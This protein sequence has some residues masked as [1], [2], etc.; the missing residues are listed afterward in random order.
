MLEAFLSLKAFYYSN[1]GQQE[2]SLN[3]PAFINKIASEIEPIEKQIKAL[4]A[5]N[6]QSQ[7]LDHFVNNSIEIMSEALA[8]KDQI[9]RELQQQL[10]QKEV[11]HE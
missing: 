1:A 8:E 9:I 7:A 5:K 2:L 3:Q 11:P 10:T 4:Q 6:N